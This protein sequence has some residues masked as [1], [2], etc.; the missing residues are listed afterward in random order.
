MVDK[1][2]QLDVI[3][4]HNPSYNE[5]STWIRTCEDIK[6]F[7]ETLNDAGYLD[8][9]DFAPDYTRKD[10][11][12]ALSRNSITVYSSYPIRN[13]VFV[14]PSEMEA[15]SYS[16]SGYVYSRTVPLDSI[17]WIDVMEGQY[18]DITDI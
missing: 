2:K 15:K 17:A 10:A 3:L 1:Q 9:N 14:T 4:K 12:R 16:A 18:A 11:E 5:T 6:T 8:Y 13:G 7:A